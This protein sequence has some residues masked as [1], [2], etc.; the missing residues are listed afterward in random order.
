LFTAAGQIPRPNTPD[1]LPMRAVVP[2]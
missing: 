2:A 1:D